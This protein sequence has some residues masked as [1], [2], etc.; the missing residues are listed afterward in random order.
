MIHRQAGLRLPL[1]HHLVQQR[2]LHLGPRVPRDVATADRDLD[3][4][5]GAEVHAE[6]AEPTCASGR[7]A[8]SGRRP[9]CRPKCSRLSRVG[10]LTEPVEQQQVARPGALLPEPRRAGAGAY[11][12]TG[13]PSNSRSA[14]RRTAR[15]SRGSRKRTIARS[16]RS[17][18]LGVA[19]GGS[20]GPAASEAD[21]H[22]AIGVGDRIR[23]TSAQAEQRR[24]GARQIL[25][26]SQGP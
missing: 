25:V 18:A 19:R 10:G 6:L 9:A 7:R 4:L 16:T 3:R 2:V 20:G 8:G 17:G 23:S 22:G 5:P 12:S 11:S 13:K 24:G 14:A 15:G 21:H 26:R 1:V